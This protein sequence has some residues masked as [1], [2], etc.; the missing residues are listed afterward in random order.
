MELPTTSPARPQRY[1]PSQATHHP[2]D[3][4]RHLLH[5][6]RR[7]CLEAVAQRLPSLEDRL[8]LFPLLA[9]GWD[10]GEDALS[11]TQEGEG[12]SEEERSAQRR[13][14][15]LPVGQNNRGGRK[16]AR[17]RRAQEGE[18]QEATF[19]G[20]YAGFGA[21]GQDPKCEGYSPRRYKAPTPTILA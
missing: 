11:P 19:T 16:R 15:G 12:P 13:D 1:R 18:G 14:S 8:P 5:R 20:G 6:S 4:E 2:R 17:L 9:P 7:L 10:V 3:P 21:H